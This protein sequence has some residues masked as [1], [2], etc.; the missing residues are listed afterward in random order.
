MASATGLTDKPIWFTNDY[1][2]YND[3]NSTRGT[4][5]LLNSEWALTVHHVVQ[6]SAGYNPITTPNFISVFVDGVGGYFADQLFVPS[7]GSEIALVHLRGGVNGAL[8]LM[9]NINT[10]FDENG[11]IVQ[12]GGYGYSGLVDTT[13][14]GGTTAGTT[15]TSASFHRAYNTI[16]GTNGLGQLL[17]N[18]NH[19]STVAANNLL[20]GMAGPGDSGGPMFAFYGTNFATQQND[21]SQWRLVGLTATSADNHWGNQSQYTRVANFSSFINNTINNFPKS[22]PSTTGTWVQ[23]VGNNLYQDGTAD[24]SV[25]NSTSAP[26]VHAKFGAGG[27]GYVLNNINDKITMT[28]RSIQPWR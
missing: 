25:S 8:N 24:I 28:P 14:A 11:R 3:N 16:Q 15:N 7:D 5:I 19:D 4:T 2:I 1:A 10:S 26:V 20:E 9:P 23:D 18:E 17:I 6:S 27:T 13:S 22:A 12:I 21:M